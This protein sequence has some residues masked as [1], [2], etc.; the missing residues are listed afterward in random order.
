V[1]VRGRGS[2]LYDVDGREYLDLVSGI[3]VT[4]L[5]HAHP[6]LAAAIAEQ[7]ATLL[8]VSNL[9]YH[10]L[11]AEAASRLAA[12]SGLPRAFFCN[13]G[14]EAVEACLKFA[15]RY[16]YT[17]GVTTRTAFVAVEGG[18]S[19]RTM[20]ALSVTHNEHY[21]APFAPL[22]GPVTFVDPNRPETLAAAVT[23]RTA[24][25][26]AEPI[27]GEG[28]VRPMS[29]AFADAI[30]TVCR[31]T[32]TLYIADEVQSGLGR[33]GAAFG[34]QPL[35]LEPDLVSVGKAL[36]S[37]VPVGA[38]LIS[39]RVA[40]AISPGDHGS[41]YGG[42][43]LAC[44][45][46]VFFLEQLMD[47]GLLD[48]VKSVGAHLERRLRT[49]AL[50]HPLILEV[51]GAGLIRG[52]ELRIDAAAVI[53]QARDHGLLVN[54]TDERVVRMLPPLTVEAADIDQAIDILD[55][56]LAAVESEVPA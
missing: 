35:G 48:H 32:G 8:H 53:D 44:R 16:W 1:F 41:T 56:V 54:R 28:G 36:G 11:Q 4:S 50:K 52:I 10:P 42:N 46:A 3:G 47:H 15:R 19:G 26:I 6:G 37:G 40:E 23:D 55:T 9:Y 43:L 34:F 13:S 20:G 31:A 30:R 45:A 18:F 25:I 24:A 12:L 14:T 2:R 27:R 33:T 21:R 5:G 29:Q 17:Q 38:A 39:E 22:I 51:R 49:L 7:A